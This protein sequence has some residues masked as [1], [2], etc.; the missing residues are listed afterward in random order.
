MFAELVDGDEISRHFVVFAPDLD[1]D[2]ASSAF[3]LASIVGDVFVKDVSER[4]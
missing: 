3:F 2:F 4:M 1:Q